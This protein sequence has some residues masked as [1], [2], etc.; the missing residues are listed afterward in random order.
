MTRPVGRDPLQAVDVD[1]IVHHVAAAAGFAGVLADKATGGGERV[2]LPD[3]ADCIRMAAFPHQR[4]VAGNIHM[5][6]AQGDTGHRLAVSTGTTPHPDVLLVVVAAADQALIDHAG[7]LMADGTVGGFHDGKGRILHHGQ[8]FHGGLAV[9]HIRNQ[10]LQLQQ[11]DEAGC[12]FAAGLRVAQLQERTGDIH[13]AKPRRA[14]LNTAFQFLV[15]LFDHQL[16]PAGGRHFQSAHTIL[17]KSNTF[18]FWFDFTTT[19]YLGQ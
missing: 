12:I 5:G 1:G 4:D 16:R 3:Q 8:S 15:Q 2:I 17:R 13:R 10:M 6:R 14:G 9:Q 18:I 19:K 7:R 11:A